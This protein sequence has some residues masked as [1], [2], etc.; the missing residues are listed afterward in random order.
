MKE[1]LKKE[2]IKWLD[3]RE[4]YPI[5]DSSWVCPVQCVPKKGGMTVVPNEKMNLFQRD[6]LLD[7]G[8]VWITA[9]KIHG[10]KKTTFLCPSWIRCWIDLPKKGGI[11]F[12]MGIWGIIRF[13]LHQNIK[14]KPLSLVHMGL[15]H[16]E[17]C[18]LGCAMHPHL[19]EMYDVNI[20]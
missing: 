19:S 4:I 1:V 18:R 12:L 2:I 9:N 17:E 5:A 8:C 6:R 11:V 15:L 7:G 20:F 3:A 14:R 16:S 10:L 13:L